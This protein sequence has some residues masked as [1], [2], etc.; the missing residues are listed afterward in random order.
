ML[1]YLYFSNEQ[2]KDGTANKFEISIYTYLPNPPL[3]P[4]LQAMALRELKMIIPNLTM[5]Y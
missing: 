2:Q 5:I 1:R 3:F 4:Y